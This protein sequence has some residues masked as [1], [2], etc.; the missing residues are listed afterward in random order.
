MANNYIK[1]SLCIECSTEEEAEWL[2]SAVNQWIDPELDQPVPPCTCERHNLNVYLYDMGDGPSDIDAVCQILQ[3]YLCQFEIEKYILL[4]WA[5]TC[6]APR[7][8][9]FGGAAVAIT[10]HNIYPFD[11]IE[12]ARTCMEEVVKKEP[13]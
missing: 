3:D 5:Y 11:P 13:Y 1:F 2:I 8:M 4:S 9:E 6:S 10:Q 12:L 7:P